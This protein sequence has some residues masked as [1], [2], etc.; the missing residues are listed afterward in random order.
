MLIRQLLCVIV[1]LF[2]VGCDAADPYLRDG[3]W[4]PNGANE[5]D[6]RAMVASPSDL[7]RGVASHGDGQQ[8]AAALDRYRNDKVRPLPD[9]AIAKV[10]PVSSGAQQG[11]Q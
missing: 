9:S 6:L 4:R 8:A 1:L 7:V 3:V 5:A 10:V 2:L 11:S